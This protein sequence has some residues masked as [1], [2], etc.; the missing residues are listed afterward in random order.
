VVDGEEEQADFATNFT[1]LQEHLAQVFGRQGAGLA[2][3]KTA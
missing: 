3:N 1:R 2:F